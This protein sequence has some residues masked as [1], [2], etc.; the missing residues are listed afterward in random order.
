MSVYTYVPKLFLK[1]EAID[2]GQ[3]IQSIVVTAWF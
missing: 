1:V 3:R 2:L